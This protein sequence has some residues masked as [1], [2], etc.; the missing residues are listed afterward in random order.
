M[1]R[2]VI[3]H[4]LGPTGGVF[5]LGLLIG[6][7]AMLVA[8]RRLISPYIQRAHAA[9]LEA[10]RVKIEV[11]EKRVVELEQIRVDYHALLLEHSQ[12]T[13]RP[14]RPGVPA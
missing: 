7:S 6:M 8:A 2:E 9:E 14:A 3:H 11:L 10:M 5:A 13:L 12:P 1:E 4:L